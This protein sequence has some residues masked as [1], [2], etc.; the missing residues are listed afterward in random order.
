MDITLGDRCADGRGDVSRRR[1]SRQTGPGSSR[2]V[3]GIRRGLERPPDSTVGRAA[4][5]PG[6]CEHRRNESS[7]PIEA[8]I[9][10][11]ISRRTPSASPFSIIDHRAWL[12]PATWLRCVWVSRRRQPGICA[13]RRQGE[14]SR[15]RSGRAGHEGRTASPYFSRRPV[16]P[17][18]RPRIG[19]VCAVCRVHAPSPRVMD[20]TQGRWMSGPSRA[21]APGDGPSD[22][23]IRPLDARAPLQS[24]P[25]RSRADARPMP[26]RDSP[27]RPARRTNCLNR[28]LPAERS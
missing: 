12:T 25:A 7:S 8:A 28:I 5:R 16:S 18:Y 22:R 3:P 23:P 1:S 20:M 9:R 10:A 19:H 24:G 27:D 15:P 17:G 6:G 26:R 4:A 2:L 21:S 11:S 14:G 13:D